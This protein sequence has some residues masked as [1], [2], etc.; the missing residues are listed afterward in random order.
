MPFTKILIANRGEIAVRIART[1]RAMGYR[2]VAVFSDADAEALHV[3]LCDQAVRIG[4]A[5]VRESYLSIGAM[6]DA[7]KRAGADAVHPGYGFLSE[8]EGFAAACEAAGL[9]F[10]GPPSSAI[11]AMG[12]KAAAKRRMLAAGVPC[13]PGYHGPDQSDRTLAGEAERIGYPLMIKAAAGGGGRGMRRVD[14]PG[15]LEQALASARSESLSAFGSDDLILERAIIEGRHIE[16]QVFAD[17]H[18]NVIHLGERDCSI[19]RRH[20]KV[21]EEAPSPVMTRELRAQMGEAAVTAAREIGY[22]GAGTVEFLLD[23][24]GAFYFL[25]MNTRLQV[26]HP[27][28]EAITGLDLVAWQL[29]VAQGERLPLGQAQVRLDGHA[30]EARLYAEA[31]QQGFLPQSG[32]VQVWQPAAGLGLRI[33]HGLEAPCAVTPHYDPMLAKIIARGAT[34]EEARRRLLLA[35]EDTVLLGIETNRAFLVEMLEHPEFVAGGATTAFIDRHFPQESMARR[36]RSDG[37]RLLALAAALLFAARI[38]DRAS[39]S[40]ADP[41]FLQSWRST[42][43]AGVPMRLLCDG[44]TREVEVVG[45][46]D[47]NFSIYFK[48]YASAA[49]DYDI[50]LVDL[51]ADS[52]RFEIQGLRQT[53][54]FVH[55]GSDVHLQ[56][57]AMTVKVTDGT[58]V[59]DARAA[60]DG[61][62]RLLAPMN[63]RIVAVLAQAGEPV[64]KGQR[65][66]VLEAMK[67]QHELTAQRDGTLAEV[68]VREGDQVAARQLVAALAPA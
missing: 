68:A 63:G 47:A 2:T 17:S 38:D 61:D 31:P 56:S 40:S 23:A 16:I 50:R 42:G 28:T 29:R 14:R 4:P 33:D 3:R 8:N 45:R 1:A 21:I 51:A 10:I 64:F 60:A 18:G 44:D 52:V 67:M 12:N 49:P 27:V 34:R 37:D 25:E 32:T 5:A 62:L 9:V 19:Q 43:D 20:Q 11:A 22:C 46:P 66:A 65:I 48:D 41:A 55:V 26:E 53:A 59:R 36:A 58:L 30:I 24:G 6:V 13:V 54:R 39:S 7:A 57:G 15:D 35:L